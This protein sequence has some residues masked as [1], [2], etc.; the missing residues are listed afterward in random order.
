[1]I[2]EDV[3]ENSPK[4]LLFP[5]LVIMVVLIFVAGMQFVGVENK[6]VKSV[7]MVGKD[8]LQ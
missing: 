6:L 7:G 1:M 8:L 2:V 3:A 4:Y 5:F